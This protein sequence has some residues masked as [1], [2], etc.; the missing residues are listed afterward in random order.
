MVEFEKSKTYIFNNSLECIYNGSSEFSVING[1]W[2][3]K[4]SE[5]QKSFKIIS[6]PH[7]R[8]I[9]KVISIEEDCGIR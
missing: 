2:N 6:C 8:D 5:D 3:F 7:E 9:V 4:L 1:A